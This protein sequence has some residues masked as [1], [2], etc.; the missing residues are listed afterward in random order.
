M[1]YATL[2]TYPPRLGN[3]PALIRA[4]SPQVDCL[5]IVLNEFEEIPD[6]CKGIAN[7][8]AHIPTKDTKDTGKFLFPVG[9]EDWLFTVDDDILY[10]DDYVK[11]S[12]SLLESTNVPNVIG[13]YHGTIYRKHPRL[14]SR[15]LRKLLGK[16]LRFVVGSRTT[17][18]FPKELTQAV[19]VEQLGT[20]VALMRGRDAPPFQA[21]RHGQK[22]VDI[23]ASRWWH[24]NKRNLV[25]LPR[26]ENWLAERE[27]VGETIVNSFTLNS[28]AQAAEEIYKFAFKNKKAGTLIDECHIS[29]FDGQ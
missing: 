28:P 6:F 24:L 18:A 14:H 15:T 19:Y 25:C 29:Y 16:D 21:I 11:T 1:I 27:P 8:E 20:G 9:D 13:G 22:F 23:V 3:L 5:R 10:P 12:I 2:A 4:I 26:P 7:V 17:F